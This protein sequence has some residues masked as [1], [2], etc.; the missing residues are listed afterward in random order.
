MFGGINS[1]CGIDE[2]GL[3]PYLGPLVITSFS[4]RSEIQ[5][6]SPE[7][8]L[9]YI[10][11]KGISR[12]D[13]SKKIFSRRK[14]DFAKIEKIFFELWSNRVSSQPHPLSIKELFGI[15]LFSKEIERICPIKPDVF[16]FSNIPIPIWVRA[17]WGMREIPENSKEQEKTRNGPEGRKYEIMFSVICPG[18]L[19][20]KVEELG[21][22]FSADAYF[23]VR[24]ALKSKSR[25]IIC[26][27]AG[28]KKSY[29]ME[30]KK[31]ISDEGE[32]G[33]I[34]IIEEGNEVSAYLVGDKIFC[35]VKDADA[36]FKQVATA[37]IIGKYIRE[38]SMLSIT[39]FAE[40]NAE[41]PFSGYGKK[42]SEKLVR[43][44][45]EKFDKMGIN[46]PK[47][48]VVREY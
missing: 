7:E 9:L 40:G 17:G 41:R 33:E 47:K 20:R 10:K 32:A 34:N 29:V 4:D 6:G 38:V 35:F 2:N 22:K 28:Y 16:C 46:I 31:A 15:S 3:G 36:K 11:G 18:F 23:M 43:V 45:K 44:M 13:D 25:F 48:C 24:M 42:N 37:S 30:I 5:I 26:G 8:F 19:H 39:K 27:K 1:I 12:E 14:N 21:S